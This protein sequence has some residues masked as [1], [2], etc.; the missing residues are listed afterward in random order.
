[1]NIAIVGAGPAGLACAS[2]LIKSTHQ[3]TMFERRV[4]SSP[5]G[6][7]VVIQPVGLAALQALG[8]REEL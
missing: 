1:M 6:S 3:I 2:Q 7:G 4:D 8:V 5:Q